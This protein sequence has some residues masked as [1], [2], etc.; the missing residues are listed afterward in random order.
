MKELT[1]ILEGQTDDINKAKTAMDDDKEV[2]LFNLEKEEL[3]N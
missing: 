3:I 2:A 1:D